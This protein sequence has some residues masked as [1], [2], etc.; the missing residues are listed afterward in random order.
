MY[1][2][3]WAQDDL[4]HKLTDAQKLPGKKINYTTLEQQDHKPSFVSDDGKIHKNKNIHTVKPTV[5]EHAKN[6]KKLSP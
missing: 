1:L 6:C 4:L 3:A 5:R 2:N